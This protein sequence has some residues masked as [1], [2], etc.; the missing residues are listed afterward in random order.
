MDM[1]NF[2]TDYFGRHKIRI[3]AD[4]KEEVFITGKIDNFR[5][6]IGLL[7][8]DI[9]YQRQGLGTKLINDFINIATLKGVKTV[10]LRADVWD[11]GITYKDLIKF[12]E[13]NK[14]ICIN[15]SKGTGMLMK[16]SI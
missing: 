10:Y 4:I 13:K 5:A 6:Y 16:R 11:R 12:Y 8:V 9:K 14:F 7:L 3:L 15:D 2:K 1:I